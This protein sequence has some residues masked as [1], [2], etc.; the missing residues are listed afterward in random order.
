M[1]N[2]INFPI[3]QYLR[4]YEDGAKD[5]KLYAASS[6][7][8]FNGFVTKYDNIVMSSGTHIRSSLID[9]NIRYVAIRETWKK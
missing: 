7:S 8:T 2:I 1:Y 3:V 6:D 4:F 9:G 5:S